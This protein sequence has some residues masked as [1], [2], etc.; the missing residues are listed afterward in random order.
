MLHVC[1][2]A[3]TALYALRFSAILARLRIDAYHCTLLRYAIYFYITYNTIIL[4]RLRIDAYRCT[5]LRELQ[6]FKTHWGIY[7]NIFLIF[8]SIYILHL[9][10]SPF[11]VSGPGGG[12]Y[13]TASAAVPLVVYAH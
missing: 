6:S 8:G 13:L 9:H 3:F 5:L 11:W 12:T 4:A 10:T 2:A 7:L 1:Y